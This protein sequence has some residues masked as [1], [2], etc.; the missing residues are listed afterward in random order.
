MGLA[1][2]RVCDNPAKT[3]VSRCLSQFFNTLLVCRHDST[4]GHVFRHSRRSASCV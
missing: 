4:I 2:S 3:V 1:P